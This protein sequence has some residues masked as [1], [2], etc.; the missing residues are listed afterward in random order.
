MPDWVTPELLA[1]TRHVWQRYYDKPLT[2]QDVS[3]IL[4]N[5]GQLFDTL[6]VPDREQQQNQAVSGVGPRVQP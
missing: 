5:I 1:D 3:A 6:G 2:D 4:L